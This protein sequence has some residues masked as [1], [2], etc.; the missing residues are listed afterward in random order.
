MRLK[1]YFQ[2]Q[3][4]VIKHAEYFYIVKTSKKKIEIKTLSC[5]SRYDLEKKSKGPKQKLDKKN[6]DSKYIFDYYEGRKLIDSTHRYFS[7]FENNKT[8]IFELKNVDEMINSFVSKTT[9]PNSE[10]FIFLETRSNLDFIKEFANNENYSYLSDIVKHV[11]EL[12]KKRKKLECTKNIYKI[13]VSFLFYK[14][15]DLICFSLCF[16]LFTLDTKLT[17]LSR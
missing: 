6:L 10:R 7:Q 13:P 17:I 5:L 11:T 4:I 3:K 1:Q 9:S 8:D 16:D 14:R 2:N 15:K 12:E